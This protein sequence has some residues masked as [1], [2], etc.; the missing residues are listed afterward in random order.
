[1]ETELSQNHTQCK[2]KPATLTLFLQFGS[3]IKKVIHDKDITLDNL[4]ILFTEKFQ[5]TLDNNSFPPFYIQD[6][7][8]KILYELEDMQDIKDHSLISLKIQGN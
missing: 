6:I 8:T 4:R 5:F 3:Q 1:M 7:H 2:Q